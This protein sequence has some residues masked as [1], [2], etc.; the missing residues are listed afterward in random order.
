[1]SLDKI[2]ED[3]A[4]M[5]SMNTHLKGVFDFRGVSDIE[6]LFIAEI[7]HDVQN[8]SGSTLRTMLCQTFA[9]S[10]ANNDLVDLCPNFW[11]NNSKETFFL[12]IWFCGFDFPSFLPKLYIFF[13]RCVVMSPCSVR[14]HW[15]NP[16]KTLYKKVR[17]VLN[18]LL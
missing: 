16:R 11:Y 18:S 8:G 9:V 5:M 7:R 14:Y 1:M 15:R 6:F 10:T 12:G 3:V 17:Y 13:V 2:L 4:S